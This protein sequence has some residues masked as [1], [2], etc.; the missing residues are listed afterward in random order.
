M[1]PK[2]GKDPYLDCNIVRCPLLPVLKKAMEKLILKTLQP[3]I[4]YNNIIPQHQFGFLKHHFTTDQNMMTY[5][6]N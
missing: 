3:Y 6:I 5:Y 4:K 1:I 2:S